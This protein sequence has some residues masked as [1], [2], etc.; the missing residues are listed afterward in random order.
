MPTR[1]DIIQ[2]GKNIA[3]ELSQ[4]IAYGHCMRKYKEVTKPP[5]RNTR[6]KGMQDSRSLDLEQ[7]PW[8]QDI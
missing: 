1:Q 6:H 7:G 8:T 3:Q 2:Q 4:A 5:Q